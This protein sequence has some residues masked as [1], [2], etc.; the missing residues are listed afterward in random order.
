MTMQ[1]ASV[2]PVFVSQDTDLKT[3]GSSTS[4]ESR[5]KEAEFSRLVEQH[6][7]D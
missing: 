2:L 6:V 4:T 5:D 1:P 3:K 7:S